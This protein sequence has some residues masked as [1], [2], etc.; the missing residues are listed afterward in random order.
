MSSDARNRLLVGQIA[1]DLNLL[2]Q[3]KLQECLELQAGQTVQRPLGEI[4]LGAGALTR[5]QWTLIQQE[6]R[7]RLSES[8]PYSK[9]SVEKISFGRILV[10]EGLAPQE[11]VDQA[12]RAQQ[13]M[14]ERGKPKRLGEILL[15]IG[16]LTEEGVVRALWLQGKAL[17]ACSSCGIQY[18]VLAVLA[19]TFPCKLCSS[20]LDGEPK[21]VRAD[22]SAYTLPAV[23]PRP[24][25]VRM[26][27]PKTSVPDPRPA[28]RPG[29]RV[30][31]KP[32]GVSWKAAILGALIG[33]GVTAGAFLLKPGPPPPKPVVAAAPLPVADPAPPPPPVAAPLAR[34][35]VAPVRRLYVDLRSAN[36]PFIGAVGIL[37]AEGNGEGQQEVRG[38]ASAA[39]TFH[40][41]PAGPKRV[42]FLPRA[43]AMPAVASIE[44]P[45]NGDA[46]AEFALK[47]SPILSGVVLDDDRKPVAGARITYTALEFLPP[48]SSGG[49]GLLFQAAAGPGAPTSCSITRL[50]TLRLST[51]TDTAG[52]FSLEGLGTVPVSVQLSAG[53]VVVDCPNLTPGE[54]AILRVPPR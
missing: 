21:G 4:L 24:T 31:L 39:L 52:R 17:R 49:A 38:A 53:K 36:G 10:R 43:G 1:L 54:S 3:E 7:R 19:D 50:G 46:R 40:G 25:T 6:Q 28:T 14:A 8:V 18:N 29:T 2:T 27:R 41:L 42:V 15:E 11:V 48:A 26:E 5:D 35:P 13:D 22:E 51:L 47:P 12:L 9:A 44:L 34:P 20:L 32:A 23:N 45:E 30:T 33:G 16:N 37:N